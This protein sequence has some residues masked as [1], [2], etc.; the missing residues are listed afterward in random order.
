MSDNTLYHFTH[1]AVYQF[2]IS[3]SITAD[4]EGAGSLGN[5]SRIRGAP[6]SDRVAGCK[7]K[8]VEKSANANSKSS[9]KKTKTG[10]P[11]NEG[12]KAG[13]VCEACSIFRNGYAPTVHNKVKYPCK[14]CVRYIQ[15]GYGG[16]I[17]RKNSSFN[18]KY[19]RSPKDGAPVRSAV[20]I[21]Q[22]IEEL[23]KDITAATHKVSQASEKC[24]KNSSFNEKYG[25]SPKDGAPV[26]SAVAITQHIEE[27]QKDITAATRKAKIN[28]LLEEAGNMMVAEDYENAAK[29]YALAVNHDPQATHPRHDEILLLQTEAE[30]NHLVHSLTQAQSSL[31]ATTEAK[32]VLLAHFAKLETDATDMRNTTLKELESRSPKDKCR[33]E[34]AMG[35]IDTLYKGEFVESD[36][37]LT[38]FVLREGQKLH[39][40][41]NEQ[42]KWAKK[43]SKV[44]QQP[45]ADWLVELE[46]GLRTQNVV[47]KGVTIPAIK[48]SI[49][50]LAMGLTYDVLSTRIQAIMMSLQQQMVVKK[51]AYISLSNYK[52]VVKQVSKQQH[53]YHA[54]QQH[55]GMKEAVARPDVLVI[56][57][58]KGDL[59]FLSANWGHLVLTLPTFMEADMQ[60]VQQSIMSENSGL[61]KLSDRA[62]R[63]IEN[64]YATTTVRWHTPANDNGNAR[65]MSVLYMLAA[66]DQHREG[67]HRN[68]HVDTQKMLPVITKLLE[69]HANNSYDVNINHIEGRER[70]DTTCVDRE[71]TVKTVT[72]DAETWQKQRTQG[73]THPLTH[74]IVKV[75]NK[76]AMVLQKLQSGMVSADTLTE[77]QLLIAT[78]LTLNSDAK[79][80][81]VEEG[82]LDAVAAYG[83]IQEA[84][85]SFWEC[86]LGK[87]AYAMQDTWSRK[88][89]CPALDHA[90]RL[91][92]DLH[93]QKVAS[94]PHLCINRSVLVH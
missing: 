54:I 9:Q 87:S 43:K 30:H 74:D 7:R 4:Q 69:A 18:E 5:R 8:A 35:I 86:L 21:T 11:K 14:T 93:N 55:K 88:V 3:M 67:Q 78:I 84:A 41:I 47:D 31:K 70:E 72:V 92:A 32:E 37:V 29:T 50:R 42:K 13:H 12:A 44:L 27:L 53:L 63:A 52:E 38:E 46:E 66:R 1:V 22:H 91:D 73:L 39:I 20:A 61:V 45:L 64:G 80:K 2:R 79:N 33:I 77:E 16:C 10:Y 36:T 82:T 34:N 17:H 23:Q 40:A 90:D 28:K 24:L 6:G 65:M 25:R 56:R 85:N 59:L 94:L 76:P 19:G 62:K 49:A 75:S 60:K 71:T 26:R 48:D 58:T 89:A 83:G 81:N 51:D 15:L 57:Q 68:T